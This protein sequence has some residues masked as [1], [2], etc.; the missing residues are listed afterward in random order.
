MTLFSVYELIPI[1]EVVYS[2]TLM[3]FL[4]DQLWNEFFTLLLN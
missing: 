2:D 3:P 4:Q 1:P